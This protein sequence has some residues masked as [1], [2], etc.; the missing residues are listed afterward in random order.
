M[1]YFRKHTDSKIYKIYITND[2]MTRGVWSTSSRRH[3]K[4]LW[5]RLTQYAR[6]AIL[7]EFTELTDEEF[8]LEML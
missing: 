3:D 4:S 5:Y 6:D 8:F 2:G 1:K 7:N